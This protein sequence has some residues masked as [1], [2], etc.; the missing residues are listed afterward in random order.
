VKEN[1]DHVLD[2]EP[3]TVMDHVHVMQDGPQHPHLDQS[4]IAQLF[5]QQTVQ[6]TEHVNVEF[7]TV[8]LDSNSSQIAHVEIAQHHV[9]QQQK[10]VLAMESV[11]VFQDFL[12]QTALFKLPVDL[13]PTVNHALLNHQTVDGVEKQM[14]VKTNMNLL[15]APNSIRPLT[16]ED[17]S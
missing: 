14:F 15:N 9:T 3:V 2:T 5:A 1:L 12:D 10:C 17:S 13:R 6:T 16:Q 4:V 8:T 11:L 7:V